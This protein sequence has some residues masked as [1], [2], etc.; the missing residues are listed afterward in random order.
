MLIRS[1]SDFNRSN[2]AFNLAYEYA[3]KGLYTLYICQ[4]EY[5]NQN[6]SKFYCIQ[7]EKSLGYWQ[8]EYLKYIEIS[9]VENYTDLL[10]LL[11]R[12][13]RFPNNPS[14]LI[15]DKASF[16]VDIHHHDKSEQNIC[17]QHNIIGYAKD[18]LNYLLTKNELDTKFIF[19]D[20]SIE[21]QIH[22]DIVLTLE[23]S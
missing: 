10:Q 20:N 16:I 13:H 12:I 1:N 4:K 17:L 3:L 19:C 14:L 6:F 7:H 21:L 11:T 22:F 5:F 9:Y 15:I 2:L 23:N 18:Y 8:P